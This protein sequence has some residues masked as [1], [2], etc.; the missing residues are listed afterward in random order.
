MSIHTVNSSVRNHQRFLL[1]G[2]RVELEQAQINSTSAESTQISNKDINNNNNCTRRAVF[3]AGDKEVTAP[4][5]PLL[6]KNTTENWRFKDILEFIDASSPNI[7]P[8]ST[9]ENLSTK[10]IIQ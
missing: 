10:V 5:S 2:V 9:Q 6:T 3:E 1:G 8:C 4:S 7:I